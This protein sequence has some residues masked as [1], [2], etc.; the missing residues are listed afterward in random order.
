MAPPPPC[1]SH[2]PPYIPSK[3]LPHPSC[4]HS[5][6]PT[7]LESQTLP[8]PHLHGR[9]LV[10]AEKQERGGAAWSG[11]GAAGRSGREGRSGEGD[12]WCLTSSD[13]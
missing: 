6:P 7:P 9:G 2:P 1:A 13:E 5:P 3:P 4:L 12:R 11:E 10:D 8:P